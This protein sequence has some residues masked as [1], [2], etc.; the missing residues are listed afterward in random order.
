[1]LPGAAGRVSSF[2]R[3]SGM[4]MGLRVL[5]F[6]KALGMVFHLSHGMT[7]SDSSVF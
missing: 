3:D 5:F 1:M 4:W 6:E 2:L 7:L